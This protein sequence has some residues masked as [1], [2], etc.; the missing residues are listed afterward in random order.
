MKATNEKRREQDTMLVW[1]RNIYGQYHVSLWA[2]NE[3][4]NGCFEYEVATGT[5]KT[6]ALWN[7]A[8]RLF[9]WRQLH[10]LWHVKKQEHHGNGLEQY[11]KKHFKIRQV[12]E[13]FFIIC[14]RH[15]ILCF[16]H[17]YDSGA[18]I[19]CSNY[20]TETRHEAESRIDEQAREQHFDYC[21]HTE[22]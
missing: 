11:R 16:L 4:G 20:R 7:L 10:L 18:E 13:N 22:L 17:F 15:T 21:I 12:S 9:R 14:Q 3:E 5:T 6:S 19:L 2:M 8:K 1:S